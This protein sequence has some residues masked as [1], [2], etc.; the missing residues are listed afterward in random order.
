MIVISV[1]DSSPRC[2]EHTAMASWP[3]TSVMSL[4]QSAAVTHLQTTDDPNLHLS[5]T[6]FYTQGLF[7]TLFKSL[8]ISCHYKTFKSK[9]RSQRPAGS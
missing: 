1:R 7:D 3:L 2:R 6:G 8:N 5:F 4:S 9:S